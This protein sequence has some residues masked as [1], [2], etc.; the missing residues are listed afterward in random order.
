MSKE[1][2][3]LRTVLRHLQGRYSTIGLIAFSLGASI[4]INVLADT[5]IVDSLISV[6]ACSDFKKI[7]YRFWELDWEND[8]VYTLFTK[9]GRK[10]KGIRPGP[11]WFKKNKPIERIKEIRT[12]V[13]FIHGEQDWVIKPWH[14]KVLYE[15]TPC[16]RALE[17]IPAGH[18]AEYLMRTSAH[19][20]MRLIKKWF[21]ETTGEKKEIP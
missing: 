18:H 16:K 3:D 7:D 12:P 19:E 21:Q 11:F 2:E 9:E 1:E 20:M 15:Q 6:S 8:L 10:G 13:L 4:S 14:S 5:Y 17:I